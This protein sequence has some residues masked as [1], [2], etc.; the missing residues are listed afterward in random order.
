MEK[1]KPRL[2]NPPAF[3]TSSAP[4]LASPQ[5]LWAIVSGFHANYDEYM[6]RLESM[7]AEAAE[8]A[9]GGGGGTGRGGKDGGKGGKAAAPL[10]PVDPE[11]TLPVRAREHACGEGRRGAG[12]VQE[13]TSKGDADEGLQRRAVLRR[14]K[15]RRRP[16]GR[17][18][19]QMLQPHVHAHANIGIRS[20]SS[21]S[22]FIVTSTSLSQPF[23]ADLSSHLLAPPLRSS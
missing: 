23:I 9:A 19:S 11:S 8:A 18:C 21:S 2:A 22:G 12:G 20:S 5:A 4:R 15:R 7:A 13:R 14:L 16:A 10:T 6:A 3:P 1:E 17:L